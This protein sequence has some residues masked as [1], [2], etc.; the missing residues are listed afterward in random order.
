MQHDQ[1]QSIKVNKKN[2][3]LQEE[4]NFKKRLQGISPE[5]IKVSTENSWQMQADRITRLSSPLLSHSTTAN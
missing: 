1:Q 4:L 2:R 3:S 5:K